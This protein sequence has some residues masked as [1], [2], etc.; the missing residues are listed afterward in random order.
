MRR[1]LAVS[2]A[3]LAL[4]VLGA[5]VW[6][7]RGEGRSTGG[8]TGIIASKR[9]RE[10][11]DIILITIDTLR[12]DSVGFAGNRDV[13]TPVLD[14]LAA[15]GRVYTNAHAHNV[16][17]LPSHTNILTGR[18][19][20]QHGV[21][22]NSGFTL[23][24]SVPTLGSLLKQAGYATA[25]FVGAY[26][27]DSRYGLGRGFD[28][29]DD[30][31][32]RGSN[33]AEFVMAERR[34]DQ[35]IAPALAWWRSQ[36]GKPRFLW[37]H[38]YDPHAAYDP[39]EPFKSRY[40]AQPYLGEIA[41]SDS[42]L[43]PLLEP[44]LDGREAPALVVVTADHGEGLG[45]HGELTHG[46]FAYE[47]TLHVPLVVW[48]A[49][50]RPGRDDR[51]ARHVDIVPTVLERLGIDPP[52]GLPGRSLLEPPAEGDS[53][54]ESLS[55]NLNRG[56]APL[57]GV[58]RGGSKWIEL[59]VPELYDLPQDPGERKNLAD[60]ER[61]TV[62]ALR[63]ALP[64][65]A[66]WP[67]RKGNVTAEEERRLRSL[68]YSVGSGTTKT[69]YT[70]DDDPKNLIGIDR[71][72]HQVIDL[73]SRGNYEEAARLGREVIA[74][75]PELAEAYE[76]AAL[77][78][79]QLERHGEAIAVLRSGIGKVVADELLRRQLGLALAETGQAKEAVEVLQPFAESGDPATLA[80]LGIAL[81][82]A[83]RPAEGEQVLRRLLAQDDSDPKAHENLGIVLL[84]RNR[85]AE[86]RDELKRALALNDRLPIAWNTLGV[87]LY[88]L[89][90]PEAALGAWR[91]AYE[92][93]PQQY[94][95]LFNTGLV[96]A[97]LGRRNEARAALSQF[98]RTAPPQRFDA[99]IRK[100]RA[101]LQE[102]GG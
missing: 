88:Q 47:A 13:S 86:A 16:V 39:P 71:K 102:I 43:A 8:D 64:E 40:A 90:G 75:R 59:P 83:G 58:I 10:A 11:V 28:V 23:P 94:D 57:R 50:V 74:E 35:V 45:D 15:A 53:Y 20:F 89:E 1:P 93:D 70:A 82:D 29:Y 19:P 56:W 31:Y 79:R 5:A 73:Y 42:F 18:Y 27:L 68:G 51:W 2:L 41:A 7:L 87:A 21:R 85:A 76:Q 92:L 84:R 80:A 33:P 95:A 6:R 66:V 101:L 9:P 38:L 49:G 61:R 46:L 12:A 26:P 78:L 30:D 48:G 100:A 55:T 25:A 4:I 17:T 44:V 34:G 97:S 37:V 77:A 52:E 22:D 69:V 67:P 60:S 62:A 99:D 63:S 14:R 3:L 36:T 65:E 32:P 54:F 96:A 81:S 91:R 72:L 98:A 24:A